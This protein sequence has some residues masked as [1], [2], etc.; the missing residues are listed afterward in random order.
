[1]NYRITKRKRIRRRKNTQ[2]REQGARSRVL[3]I[4]ENINLVISREDRVNT[5]PEANNNKDHNSARKVSIQG[6]VE[7]RDK[8]RISLN[9]KIKMLPVTIRVRKGNSHLVSKKEKD[10]NHLINQVKSPGINIITGIKTKALVLK[11]DSHR[12]QINRQH[13]L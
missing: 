4:G 10:N 6:K 7:V 11:E 3:I 1:L 8:K 12:N 13:D 5:N 9:H 2:S